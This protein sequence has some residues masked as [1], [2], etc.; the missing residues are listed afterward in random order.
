MVIYGWSSTPGRRLDIGMVHDC[1]WRHNLRLWLG[2][3]GNGVLEGEYSQDGK[4]SWKTGT[5]PTVEGDWLDRGDGNDLIFDSSGDDQIFGGNGSDLLLA[6]DGADYLDGGED[7]DVLIGEDGDDTLFGGAGNDMLYGGVGNDTL[8]GGTGHDALFGGEGAD[9][10][11]GGAGNDLLQG[12]QGDDDLFGGE[13]NDHYKFKPGDGQD[14]IDDWQGED[15][16]EILGVSRDNCRFEG[17]PT[18]G[19]LIIRYSPFDSITFIDAMDHDDWSLVIGGN[20]V[21]LDE[22]RGLLADGIHRTDYPVN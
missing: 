11:S 3:A 7:N 2:L 18:G 19:T 6:W 13:G 1:I 22:I 21:A 20:N 15:S 9:W 14:I 16:L 4:W 12:D 8:G 10:L 17:N 5:R